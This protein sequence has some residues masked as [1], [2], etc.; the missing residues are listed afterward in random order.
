MKVALFWPDAEAGEYLL[1][2]FTGRG[3]FVYV[4]SDAPETLKFDSM[5]YEIQRGARTDAAAMERVVALADVVI[6]L[7]PPQVLRGKRKDVSTPFADGI[8]CVLSVMKKCGK[9]RL[10][11]TAP[12]AESEQKQ[13]RTARAFGKLLRKFFPHT[14]RDVCKCYEAIRSSGTDY[15]VLRYMNPYLKHAKDGYVL[16]EGDAKA[17]TGVSMENLAQCLFDIVVADSY[18]GQMPIVY[19]KHQS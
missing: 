13:G 7:C 12:V 2:K 11:V 4:Y 14:Y 5:L 15:T 3:D 19:N 16:A 6:C 1:K 18:K 8:A 10:F 17:K 9:T